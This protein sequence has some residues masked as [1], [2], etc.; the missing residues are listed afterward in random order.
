MFR[1]RLLD[2]LHRKSGVRKKG[3]TRGWE[4]M[5]SYSFQ[6]CIT[7]G[8]VKGTPASDIATVLDKMRPCSWQ[9]G[10]PMLLPITM[11]SKEL[12]HRN[13]EKQR[14]IRQ[15]LRRLE[16]AILGH[17]EEGFSP[18]QIADVEGLSRDIIECGAHTLMKRPQAYMRLIQRME[19]CMQ[20]VKQQWHTALHVDSYLHATGIPVNRTDD[21][22]VLNHQ[23]ILFKTHETLLSHLDFYQSKTESLE[24]YI[25]TTLRRLESQ[26]EGVSE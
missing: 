14:E 23:K 11:L 15:W 5:L 1:F 6:T 10:H 26:R 2:I 4:I 16:N 21:P 9:I 24:S 17:G 12:D 3:K 13:D 22:A 19:K 25:A 18:D 7:V 8:F 20:V